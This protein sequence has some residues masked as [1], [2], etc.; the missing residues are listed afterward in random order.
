MTEN[1]L[2]RP[3]GATG[4]AAPAAP[5][6]GAAVPSGRIPPLRVWTMLA[7]RP[8]ISFICLLAVA[9]AYALRGSDHPFADSAAWWL[10]FITL[11]NFATIFALVRCAK[12]EG[13]RLRDIYRLSPST[14]KGDLIWTAAGFIGIAL[15]AQAPGEALAR[16]LWGSS[17]VPNGMLIGPLP[18]FAVYPLFVLFPVS[19]G[20]A[21]LPLYFGY[22]APRLRTLG[23]PRAILIAAAVLSV[24]HLFI[25]FQP[26]WRYCLWLAVKFLPFALLVGIL[27]DRRPTILPYLMGG[28]LLLDAS[29][30]FLV[31]LVS[32]G[33]ELF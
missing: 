25:S 6:D 16:L 19:H 13:L 9:G 31:L 18:V 26:D 22:V 7:L 11:A 29:L 32:R 10:W 28:H 1:D 8:G 21:E 14:W 27:I 15:V 33:V 5:V 23:R 30:P 4:G 3:L 12:A 2:Q 24:Q 20:L 17:S